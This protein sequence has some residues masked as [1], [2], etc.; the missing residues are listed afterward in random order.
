MSHDALSAESETKGDFHY[1]CVMRDTSVS[2]EQ[3]ERYMARE[4]DKHTY[5][6]RFMKDGKLVERLKEVPFGTVMY[7]VEKFLKEE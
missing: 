7:L 3:I 2:F 6:V 4:G 5:L 1:F